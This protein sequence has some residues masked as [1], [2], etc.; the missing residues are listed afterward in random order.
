MT[1]TEWRW[2]GTRS[3]GQSFEM[4]GV[5]LFEITDDRIESPG[6]CTWRTSSGTLPVSSRPWKPSPAHGRGRR[7][8]RTARRP[9]ASRRTVSERA[10]ASELTCRVQLVVAVLWAT[11]PSPAQRAW[12]GKRNGSG[13][14]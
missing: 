9:P 5:T 11:L 8:S 7:S 2:S 12:P 13:I 3:D 4:R 6:G 1:W 10:S 14:W